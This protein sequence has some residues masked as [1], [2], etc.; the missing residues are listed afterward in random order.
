[1]QPRLY[2]LG[3][4][5]GPEIFYRYLN[6]FG[7]GKKTGIELPGEA[8]GIL[9]NQKRAKE[10]DL[11]TMSIGQANA[12]TPLQLVTAV[13]AM[14]NGGK[15]M[16]PQIVKEIRDNKGKLVKTI[17]PEV[18]RQVISPETGKLVMSILETVVSE[19]TGANAYVEGYRIGGKTGTAQK[20][21]P[22]GGYSSSE[23]IGSFLGVAPV[24]NPQL[25]CLV[26][27]DSPKGIYYGGQVAAPAFKNIIRDSLRYL[28]YPVQV[29]P[30]RIA[31]H[32]KKIVK[33]PNLV[34]MEV[35]KAVKILDDN[36]LKHNVLG[37]GTKV[38]VQIPLAGTNVTEDS[39]VVLYS[40]IPSDK[41]GPET[42]AV[43][44]FTGKNIGEV[45]TLAKMLNLNFEIQGSGIVVRQEPEPGNNM[46]VGG[47]VK[48]YMDIPVKETV[49]PTP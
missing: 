15:L 21:I 32:N 28:Q 26:V 29:D 10:I 5:E 44:D 24:D 27:V 31:G 45:R 22:G 39:K 46:P 9:V 41:G 40:S 37:K 18:V 35:E 23:Y 1:M 2:N 6:G 19:G 25:V 48:I 8:T 11:A 20:I 12:V 4:R 16:K 43:P 36:N 33:L 13:S 42:V 47:K 7:F 3:L 38:K 34:G 17:K 14:A 49:Q 30:E